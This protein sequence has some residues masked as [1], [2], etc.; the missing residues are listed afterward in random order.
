[1]NDLQFITGPSVADIDGLPGEEIVGG[2]ASLDLFA[3]NAAG[4]PAS[5]E[6]AEAD[7]G[8]DRRGPGDRLV[9]HARHGQLGAQGDRRR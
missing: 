9:R 2:S 1:M 7:L 8:L 6:V 4:A 5:G 3:F